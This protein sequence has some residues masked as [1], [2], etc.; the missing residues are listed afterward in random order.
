[1]PYRLTL[2]ENLPPQAPAALTVTCTYNNGN[3]P[4]V[5]N[6]QAVGA[7]T[8]T[9][10]LVVNC[11]QNLLNIPNVATRTLNA[12]YPQAPNVRNIAIS[13]VQPSA[14]ALGGQPANPSSLTHQETAMSTSYSINIAMS[15]ATVT[16]LTDQKFNLYGF[17]AVKTSAG[18][19]APVVWFKA[20]PGSYGLSTTVAWS[21]QYQAY[22]TNSTA[23]TNGQITNVNAYDID[24]AQTLDVSSSSG[25][26]TVDGAHGTPSA[27]SIYN[28]TTSPFV[29]GIS[30][31]QGGVAQPMCAFPLNGKMIDVIAP[32]EK[33]VLMFATDSFNTGSVIFQAVGQTALIDL[34]D[35]QSVN[36][37]FDINNGWGPTSNPDVHVL[38][39][40][41]DLTPLVIQQTNSSSSLTRN[42]A[43]SRLHRR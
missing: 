26:G 9:A 7:D 33:V 20:L 3:A 37:T 13:S 23:I 19:G 36:I 6:V 25:T 39:P 42:I 12:H 16:G 22:T 43:Q 31:L 10:V 17:K 4:T 35:A 18:G 14:A 38:D 5:W 29:C 27:I 32:I 34:T 28:Q 21:E 15:Q 24:L 41:V 2:L 30:Q 40:Q 1:M 11:A 8:N